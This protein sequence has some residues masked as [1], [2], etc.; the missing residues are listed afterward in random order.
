MPLSPRIAIVT[1]ITLATTEAGARAHAVRI[2]VPGAAR[3]TVEYSAN[4]G[5]TWTRVSG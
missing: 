4:E 2:T 5:A 3:V 1:A